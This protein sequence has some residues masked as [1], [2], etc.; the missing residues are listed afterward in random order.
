MKKLS[1][2]LFAMLCLTSCAQRPTTEVSSPIPSSAISGESSSS[3]E[4]SLPIQ[5]V[6]PAIQQLADELRDPAFK[7]V[8][9]FAQELETGEYGEPKSD[10]FREG[11]AELLLTGPYE[12]TTQLEHG[13]LE[14]E[15]DSH[16][17][18]IGVVGEEHWT[19]INCH[20][21]PASYGELAGKLYIEVTLST[22]IVQDMIYYDLA[23]ASCYLYSGD[24]YEKTITLIKSEIANS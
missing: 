21:L 4:S 17:I 23:N 22:E 8:V 15:T 2:I 6:D 20:L 19:Q 5:V 10:A 13:T 1:L 11:L 12:L 3:Q 16:S 9:D 7:T 18:Q 14:T 24:V